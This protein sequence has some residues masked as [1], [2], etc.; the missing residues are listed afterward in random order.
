MPTRL[1]KIN[2]NDKDHEVVATPETTL[3]ETL[4]ETLKLTGVR[5]GCREGGCGSCS[6]IVDGKL[7]QSCLLPLARVE[8]AKIETI[9]GMA[10]SLDELHPIQQS[11]IDNGA[12]QC[13]FCTSGM[14]TSAKS[15]LESNP[16]PSREEILVAISGNVC[17]CTG[18]ESIVNAI[19]D[20]AA[21][22][23]R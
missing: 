20:A 8:G 5:A 17:R 12:T 3:L 1:I 19:A 13:G 2:V 7:K 22:S 4:R 11:F 10:P 6:V 21:R 18:Y 14:I 15:L 16:K 23:W 9:E